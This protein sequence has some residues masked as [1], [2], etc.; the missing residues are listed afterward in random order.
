[1]KNPA[2]VISIIGVVLAIGAG[3]F[4]WWSPQGQSLFG[5]RERLS[6]LSIPGELF[7]PLEE[8]AFFPGPLRKEGGADSVLLT[9]IGVIRET[10]AQRAQNSLPA[11]KENTQLNK[12]AAT[13]LAD[14]F[15]KQYFEHISP[16]GVG[17]SDLAEKIGYQY[18]VVGENLALGNFANDRELVQAWMDS[19][20]HRENILNKRFTEIGV[21]VGK[22]QFEGKSVWLAVQSFGSPLSSC[23]VI[24]A[25]LQQQI[26]ANQ[27]L[28]KTMEQQ[29]AV[30]R[31]DIEQEHNKEE[32]NRKVEEYNARVSQFNV[33]V[34]QT[35]IQVATYNAQVNAFN[36]CVNAE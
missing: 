10:N 7:T 15:A 26:T 30:L 13:K 5:L 32:Y 17:P 4:L 35:K 25:S 11:L 9:R 24:D 22:G 12:V 21:A 3:L 2:R 6:Q 8:R 16:S 1:M 14:M 36:E 18:I 23:P 31:K 20:G 33:L 34:E 28:L 19:R 29:L 27:A